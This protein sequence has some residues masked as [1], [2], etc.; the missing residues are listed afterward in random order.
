M[1]YN[2]S[3][4]RSLIQQGAII[5][6]NIL[7]KDEDDSDDED[8]D[9]PKQIFCMVAAD[10]PDIPVFGVMLKNDGEVVLYRKYPRL[11]LRSH[12]DAHPHY[13]Q[14]ATEVKQLAELIEKKKVFLRLYFYTL[15]IKIF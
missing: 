3:N 8:E 5:D 15:I 12:S 2:H 9:R 1:I 10:S 11:L 14:K 6:P 7:D 13:K 4:F